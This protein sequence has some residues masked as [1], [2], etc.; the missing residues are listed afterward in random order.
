[1]PKIRRPN[2]TTEEKKTMF[3][4]ILPTMMWNISRVCE[5]VDINRATYYV[6]LKEDPGFCDQV[7]LLKEARLDFI[8]QRSLELVNALDGPQIRFELLHLGKG[9]GYGQAD[10][11]RSI[12]A[13]QHLHF[14]L[15]PQPAD[16]A[17]WERQTIEA[18]E[19]RKALLKEDRTPDPAFDPLT[20]KETKERALVRVS[21]TP[22]NVL[23][24]E[25]MKNVTPQVLKEDLAGATDTSEEG[26]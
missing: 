12:P 24:S 18:R 23:T 14:H 9:R 11:D 5:A 1:M 16:L 13:S 15:P 22:I 8:Q 26:E 25:A 20:V 19:A 4:A 6:W 21:D 2:L 7:A 17:D 10:S 3:L